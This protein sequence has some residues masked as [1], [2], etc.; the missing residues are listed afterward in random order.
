MGLAVR[1]RATVRDDEEV[2]AT[3]RPPR[4][5]QHPPYHLPV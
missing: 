4:R 5:Q 2:K 3:Q 1:G